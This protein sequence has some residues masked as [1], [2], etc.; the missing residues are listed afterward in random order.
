MGCRERFLSRKVGVVLCLFLFKGGEVLEVFWGCFG[1][2][3]VL[4]SSWTKLA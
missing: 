4:G 3:G 2:E 1:L